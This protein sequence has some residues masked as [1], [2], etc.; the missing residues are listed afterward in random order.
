MSSLIDEYTKNKS[1]DDK[2]E[3]ERR[4]REMTGN[5]SELSALMLVLEEMRQEKKAEGGRIGLKE[6]LGSFETSDPKEAMKEV[7]KRFLEKN[8]ETTT[9]PISENIFLNLAPGVSD[10][11]LGGIMKKEFNKGGRVNYQ[12]GTPERKD[13]ETPVTDAIKSV[14]EK[15]Q[16]LIMKGTDAFDKYS[17]IDQITGSNFPG[18][19]DAASGQPSDFR[20]QAASNLLAE[21]LG[22]GSYTDPILGPISYLSGGIGATGLGAIKEVGD[23]VSSLVESPEEYKD[24]FSEFLK[25]NLSNIKGAFAKPGTTT[26]ELYETLMAGYVPNRR[27]SMLPMDNAAQIFMQRRKA[28]ED[29]MK[30]QKDFTKQKDVIIPPKKPTTTKPGTGGGTGGGGFTPTTT[31]QNIARTASRVDS[32]GNVKA[33]G[34]A[35]GGLARMLGE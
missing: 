19:Y 35:K 26:E 18:A 34:L 5:M 8:I 32:S 13:Y 11:E 16:D 24:A 33:Y 1:P 29:A 25:D 2:K 28:L 7:I 10:V 20:H 22:K 31:A 12:E 15:T 3:V 21:A 23:L 14:N 6:G 27:F 4:V 17:G 9:V 30:K